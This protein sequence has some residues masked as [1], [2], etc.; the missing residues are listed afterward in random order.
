MTKANVNGTEIHY[1]VQGIGEPLVLLMGLGAYGRKW[2]KHLVAYRQHFQCII[3]DNRGSGYSDKPK[4][5]AYTTD[6]MAEDTL[7]VLDALGIQEAHF[8]GISM[9]GAVCQIVAAKYPQRVRSLILTSTFAKPG[10]F[11][12]RALEILRDSVGVLDG[13]TFAHLCQ[14]M[15]YSPQY[16]EAHLDR[17]LADEAE[18]A[19]DPCPMPAYAYR[20]QCNAC[21]THNATDLLKDIK[22]PTLV[23][24]GD[25]DLFVSRETTRQLVEGIGGAR[26]YLCKDGG[27][28]HHWEKLEQFNEVTLGFLLNH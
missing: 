13:E 2:E 24:A 25:S 22:A 28:V 3:I 26:L 15:I 12:T 20:A 9:G 27:H 17:I 4:L 18:D 10:A 1:E 16:H 8:H 11:F 6:M 7:G 21:I 23:A 5:D 19:D 14:Y